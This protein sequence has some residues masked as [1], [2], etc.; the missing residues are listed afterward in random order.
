[1]PATRLWILITVADRKW[2][3]NLRPARR[4]V[5]ATRYEPSH[6]DGIFDTVIE[7]VDLK[8][9]R[10][11]AS[12]RTSQFLWAFLGDG[13]VVRDGT[14]PGGV[15]RFSI[16]RLDTRFDQEKGGVRFASR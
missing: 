14:G 7:V 4:G 3:R 11:L 15:P 9:G 8:R 2:R 12:Q 5:G 13:L 10:L 6:P 1:M 16:W